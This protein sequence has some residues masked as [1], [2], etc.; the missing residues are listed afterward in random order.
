MKTITST[1]AQASL[2]DIFARINQ[3]G[4]VRVTT[5]GRIVAVIIPPEQDNSSTGN[6]ERLLTLA[7]SYAEGITSWS[8]IKE[9]LDI[10]YGELL[11]A[12]K[13]QGLKIPQCTARKTDEQIALFNRALTM[14]LDKFEPIE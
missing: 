9:T 14:H 4:A 1:E 6:A 7:R 10:S 11:D 13:I 3:T 2:G 12:L 5:R 8:E